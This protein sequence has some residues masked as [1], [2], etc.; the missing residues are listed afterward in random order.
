MAVKGALQLR[1]ELMER[2]FGAPRPMLYL[3][4]RQPV[5]LLE[6]QLGAAHC[7][8]PLQ[9]D[10]A[11]VARHFAHPRFS[12]PRFSTPRFSIPHVCYV[13]SYSQCGSGF[14]KFETENTDEQARTQASYN[15]VAALIETAGG[16][17][18]LLFCTQGSWRKKPAAQRQVS[19]AEF[20]QPAFKL[21]LGEL[22]QVG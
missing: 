14:L 5:P 10:E 17:A 11:A 7:V 8:Y 6:W 15:A 1:R 18:D 13:G 22:V 2:R 20:R 19:L 12:T 16:V 9:S 4:T 21:A 3:A